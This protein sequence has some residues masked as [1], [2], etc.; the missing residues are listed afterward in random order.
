[1]PGPKPEIPSEAVGVPVA[2]FAAGAEAAVAL[3]LPSSVAATT[4]ATG[5][6]SR[7]NAAFDRLVTMTAVSS[8]PI[9]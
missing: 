4:Q 6:R 3:Q 2:V 1:M 7:T 8:F 5:V 9:D